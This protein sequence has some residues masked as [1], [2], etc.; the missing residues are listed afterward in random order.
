MGRRYY[1]LVTKAI[2]SLFVVCAFCRC[3]PT[4]PQFE[5]MIGTWRAKDGA[6]IQLNADSTFVIKNF[7]S[8]FFHELSDNAVRYKVNA[9]G[10]WSIWSRDRLGNLILS[11]GISYAVKSSDSLF[12]SDKKKWIIDG[13]STGFYIKG[14]G[15]F[16]TDKAPWFIR[17]IDNFDDYTIYDFHRVE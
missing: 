1:N 15:G 4:P 6:V 7:D 5:E 14:D 16:L 3:T 9:E 10:K 13:Y 2:F 11:V 8:Y 12:I 17:V